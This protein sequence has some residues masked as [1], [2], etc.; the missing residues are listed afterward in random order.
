MAASSQTTGLWFAVFGFSSQ[1]RCD[2]SRNVTLVVEDGKEFKVKGD[3]SQIMHLEK[4]G[5]TISS[6]AFVIRLNL[7]LS[8]PSFFSFGLLLHL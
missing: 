1:E 2:L 5:P 4:I 3:T 6:L 7:P 8:Q